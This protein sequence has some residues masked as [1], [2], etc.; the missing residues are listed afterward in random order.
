MRAR[1]GVLVHELARVGDEADVQA[2]EISGVS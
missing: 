2:L 1:I